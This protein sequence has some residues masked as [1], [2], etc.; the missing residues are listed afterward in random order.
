MLD[1]IIKGATV[2]DGTGAPGYVA[3][4]GI[5]G[6]RIAA[7]AAPGTIDEPA[8]RIVDPAGLVLPPGFAAPPP[9]YAPQL[10]GDPDASPSNVHGATTVMG[11]NCGFP[12]APIRAGDADSTRRMMA[13]VEGM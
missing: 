8:E 11:G 2:V 12:L 13:K 4:V 10:L 5:R 3:D 1:E 7:V 9:P 6:G